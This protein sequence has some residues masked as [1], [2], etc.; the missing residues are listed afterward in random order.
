MPIRG[1]LKVMRGVARCCWTQPLPKYA[2]R[3]P[4]C[5]QT[6]ESRYVMKITG[7]CLTFKIR[8]PTTPGG[9][10]RRRTHGATPPSLPTSLVLGLCAAAVLPVAQQLGERERGRQHVRAAGGAELALRRRDGHEE[11][12]A[13]E[14]RE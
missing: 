7:A 2:A 13:K 12:G 1:G 4:T 8:M 3:D 5:A 6:Y 14:E 9:P 11:E 10:T